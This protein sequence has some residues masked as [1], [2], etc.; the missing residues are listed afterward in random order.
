MAHDEAPDYDGLLETLAAPEPAAIAAAWARTS[1]DDLEQRTRALARDVAAASRG[2][3]EM[4]GIW[5]CWS[6]SWRRMSRG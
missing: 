5:L 6:G 3:A 2:R 4:S 1:G